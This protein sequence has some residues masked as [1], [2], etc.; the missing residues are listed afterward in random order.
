MKLSI[1]TIN[2]NNCEGLKKTIDSVV[3]QTWQE[4]E[5]IIVDGGS[6]D[7]SRELIEETAARLQSEG[8]PVE[9]FSLLGFTA[10]DRK[11]YPGPPEGKEN[12]DSVSNVKVLKWCSEPDE[13]I[14]N[15]MNKD[16]VKALGE[17]CLFLNSG[18]C[19]YVA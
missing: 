14:Y 9:P 15:V 19:K 17:Y 3:N 10:E 5:W 4:F 8:W 16:I 11:A 1:I 18:D 7:G 2:Y 6:N 13:G 12:V